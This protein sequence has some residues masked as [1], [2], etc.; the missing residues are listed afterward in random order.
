MNRFNSR[1]AAAIL[2]GLGF[3]HAALGLVLGRS[4]R[5][6]APP[7]LGAAAAEAG[8]D[9][10]K[11][12]ALLVE[13]EAWLVDVRPRDAFAAYHLPGATS[14][15]GAGAGQLTERLGAHPVIVV[16]A[17][18]DEVARRLV[19][20]ARLAAPGAR[21]HYVVDGARAWYLAFDLPV[22]LFAEAAPPDGYRD[23]LRAVKGWFLYRGTRTRGTTVEALRTLARVNYQP[24]LLGARRKAASGGQRN[25]IGGGCG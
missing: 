13:T 4:A 19:A 9:A 6:E 15:P 25:K 16:Y 20:E 7:D 12:A 8:L 10:W 3:V 17:E 23:A 5:A 18:K 21:I 1:V 14:L 11:A 22:A 2:I 24:S